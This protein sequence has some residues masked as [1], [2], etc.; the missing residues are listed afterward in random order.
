[1]PKSD[2][3]SGE[4]SSSTRAPDGLGRDLRRYASHTTIRLLAGMV[5]LLLIIGNGLI[6]LI[7]GE[8]AVRASLLC[9]LVFF[10]PVILISLLL[11]L[12]GW[13]SKRGVDD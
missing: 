10:M 13:V 1:M 5:I 7:Y 9:M 12:A 6:L 11:A 8:G 3:P 2:E 4:R